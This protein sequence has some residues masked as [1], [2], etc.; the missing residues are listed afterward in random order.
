MAPRTASLLPDLFPQLEVGCFSSDL[1]HVPGFADN[2]DAVQLTKWEHP[3]GAEGKQR[4]GMSWRA[5][6]VA[7]TSRE[8]APTH[9]GAL[10]GN[11]VRLRTRVSSEQC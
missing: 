2:D 8:A 3:Y 9:V 7:R 11:T 5:E 4:T 10:L 1:V 6:R